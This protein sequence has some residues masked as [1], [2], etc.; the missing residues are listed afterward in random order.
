MRPNAFLIATVA[1]ALLLACK[2][3]TKPDEV[4]MYD[5]GQGRVLSQS[6]TLE[7]LESARIVLVGE[8]H[9]NA[10]HHAAQLKVIQLLHN[11]GR[12]VAVGLEMFRKE[13]QQAL[14]QWTAGRI[15]EAQFESIYLDN[16]NFGWELYGPIFKYAR[17]RQIPM[18]GLNVPRKITLQVAYH[19]FDS[20]SDEQRGVLEG[21]TC[22]VSAEY[23][24][25]IRYAYGAHG[26][27]KM[28]FSSFC[29]AQLVW[30]A[31]MAVHAVDYLKQHPD[32]VLVLLAG[33]GHA[34]KPGI[35]T[36]LKQR[37]DWLCAVVLPE[38][39]GI[40]DTEAI[41]V[42]DADYILLKN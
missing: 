4:R 41:S 14:D 35:P 34:R 39:K 19:G 11:A 28:D 15:G 33:S 37:A 31:A 22:N 29:E 10:A 12:E 25:Y 9:T 18:V 2:T 6:Q 42:K 26:H 21:I 27:G 16:W 38:T 17:D 8:H 30:D 32:R 36:Q 23:R 13:S 3:P 20:L 1:A 5:L 24:E 40:F 7:K